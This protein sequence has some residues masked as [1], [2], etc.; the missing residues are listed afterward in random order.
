MKAVILAGGEGTRLRPITYEIPK[1][2]I[3]V[4]KKA[5]VEHLSELLCKYEIEE[6]GILASEKHKQDYV[7]WQ[8]KRG[9]M[10]IRLFYEPR[11]YGT[12]GWL[13]NLKEWLGDDS[14]IVINGDTLLDIDI[15]ELKDVHKKQNLIATIALI[16]TDDTNARGIAVLEDGLVTKF[17]YKKREN[18]PSLISAGCVIFSPEVFSYS[19]EKEFIMIE[20]DILPSLVGERKLSGVEMKDG[21]CYDCGTLDRWEKA[22]KE[23]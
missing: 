22:I 1:P 15:N 8:K 14:F 17:E 7:K 5:I 11:P 23:W 10:S 3:T 18:E 19:P 20:D 16:H 13:K 4:K 6:I 21:R 12:F 9:L 2:L